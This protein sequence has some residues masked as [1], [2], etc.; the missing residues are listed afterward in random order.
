MKDIEL[1]TTCSTIIGIS[2]CYLPE[3][4]ELNAKIYCSIP[5]KEAEEPDIVDEWKRIPASGR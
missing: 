1:N 2:I 3:V 5:A 4:K